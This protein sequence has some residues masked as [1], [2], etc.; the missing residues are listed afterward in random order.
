MRIAQKKKVEHQ[1]KM[2]SKLVT[3]DAEITGYVSKKIKKLKGVKAKELMLWPP[4]SEITVDVP[5]TGNTV[6]ESCRYHRLSQSRPLLL[7]SDFN[8]CLKETKVQ[9]P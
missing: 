2:I 4:A 9:F 5:P 1:F 3:Y 6:Q 7:A 8:G